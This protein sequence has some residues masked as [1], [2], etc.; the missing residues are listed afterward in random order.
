MFVTIKD[1]TKFAIE[2]KVNQNKTA[3]NQSYGNEVIKQKLTA[4][5]NKYYDYEGVMKRFG[6]SLRLWFT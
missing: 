6:K 4:E 3:Y 2:I 5:Y 1:Y